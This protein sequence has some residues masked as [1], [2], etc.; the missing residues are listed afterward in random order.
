MKPLSKGLLFA[1]QMAA[2]ESGVAKHQYIE[3][4]QI[5]IGICSLEKV[6]TSRR[7]N[8]NRELQAIKNEY[9]SIERLLRKFK[10]NSTT[11]RRELRKCYGQGDFGHYEKVIH[12]SEECKEIFTRAELLAKNSDKILCI[13]LLAV[14]MENPKGSIEQILKNRRIKWKE[15]QEK[16]LLF[17][18]A[19]QKD[20]NNDSYII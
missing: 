20:N 14:I 5:L 18:R 8:S 7:P 4:E 13:H 19:S 16:T 9:N 6:F 11:L 10:L 15:I 12:R 2:I 17:A 1:W 3:K